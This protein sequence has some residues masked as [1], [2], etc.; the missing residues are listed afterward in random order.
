MLHIRWFKALIIIFV[1]YYVQIIMNSLPNHV[2]RVRVRFSWM[3]SKGIYI[4]LNMKITQIVNS[5]E[6]SKRKDLRQIAKAK[7]KTQQTKWLPHAWLCSVSFVCREWLVE[8]NLILSLT[9]YL[10]DRHIKLHFI[11]NDEWPKHIMKD[12][13]F[14]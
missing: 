13:I 3:K 14:T 12:S 9:S 10:Y 5:E 6:N 11:D 7:D 1:F 2:L 8:L 4:T